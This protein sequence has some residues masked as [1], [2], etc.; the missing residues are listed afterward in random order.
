VQFNVF[1]A[2]IS[3][4]FS[5]GFTMEWLEEYAISPWIS[6]STHANEIVCP[7]SLRPSTLQRTVVHHPWIDLFPVPKMR[8]NLLLA[9]DSYD[10][11]ALCNELVNFCNVTHDKTGLVVWRDPWDPSGW[12]IS[13][14]FL[15]KW[16]WVVDGCDEL[17]QSTNYWRMT[18]GENVLFF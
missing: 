16:G 1:R 9:G 17:L 6:N 4:T 13:E 7:E 18:R 14:S 11:Y 8:D 15:S 3:N 2:L 5:M 10:E 12:E